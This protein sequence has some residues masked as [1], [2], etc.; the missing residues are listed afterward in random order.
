MQNLLNKIFYDARTHYQWLDKDVPNELL[1]SIHQAT[2][3]GPTSA[4]C[5]PQRIVF[6]KSPEAKEKLRSILD[7]GNIEKTMTAPV[8]ALFGFDLE[9]YEKLPQ[10]FP[11]AD[12]R[13]WFVGKPDHIQDTAFRN[14]TLQAAYFI[15]AA[16]AHGLD[17][18][19][20]SGF[21]QEKANDT[22]FTDGKIKSNFLCNL[23][24]GQEGYLHPRLPRFDF[25]ESCKI[26]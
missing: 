17:C 25:D 22:F 19:P 14:A 24:Y 13:S 2:V 15:I 3:M 6:I 5:A 9:F 1:E 21:N 7:P 4:N 10:L 8:T 23:G 20:M 18:G 12:A 26:V 16:R 11:H